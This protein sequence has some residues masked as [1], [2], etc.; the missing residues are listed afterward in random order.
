M[1]KLPARNLENANAT[2]KHFLTIFKF[3]SMISL[4]DLSKMAEVIKLS[5]KVHC[6][7]SPHFS[8][9]GVWILLSLFGSKVISNI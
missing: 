8:I 4:K 2:E 7:W 3:Y 5:F 1:F 6:V 9:P